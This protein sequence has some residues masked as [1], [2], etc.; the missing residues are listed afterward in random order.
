MQSTYYSKHGNSIC[1]RKKNK[2]FDFPHQLQY[3]T[4]HDD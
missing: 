2:S 4:V 3:G 1:A